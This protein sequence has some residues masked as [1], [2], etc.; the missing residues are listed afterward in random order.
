MNTGVGQTECC[1]REYISS[2]NIQTNNF[3]FGVTESAQ[4]NTH[5]ATL[6]RFFES[7]LDYT[8]DTLL[9][10]AVGNNISVGSTLVRP[11]VGVQRGLR[12]L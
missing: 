10:T 12:M 9:I 2:F 11:D 4:G 3:V 1:D 6:L 8:V 5:G 7:Q